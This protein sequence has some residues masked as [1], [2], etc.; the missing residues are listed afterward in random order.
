M[1]KFSV[2]VL[3]ALAL[4]A[5]C[6]V[7]ADPV[8]DELYDDVL[9]DYDDD[10]EGSEDEFSQLAVTP[11]DDEETRY[12]P[13]DQK[14][15][16][17]YCIKSRN[18]IFKFVTD[19]TNHAA[20]MVFNNIFNTVGDV[21]TQII[22]IEREATDEGAKMIKNEIPIVNHG[23]T[24]PGEA[25]EQL[26]ESIEQIIPLK[27]RASAAVA[28]V[29]G[30][31]IDVASTSVFQRLSELRARFTPETIKEYFEIICGEVK[32][33]VTKKIDDQFNISKKRILQ[34]FKNMPDASQELLASVSRV[35]VDSVNCVTTSRVKKL[36]KFC[37]LMTL[38]GPT[39]WPLIGVQE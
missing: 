7:Q 17:D 38:I 15:F 11:T 33:A 1:N 30:A 31:V 27:A 36:S 23:K 39:V 28:N 18:M 12:L 2:L 10:E 37:D 22:N 32:F 14:I 21:A 19:S 34:D 9:E 24:K 20:S 3:A 29:L 5:F 26:D 13:P 6:Q 8:P 16:N 25:Q 35:K 4:L